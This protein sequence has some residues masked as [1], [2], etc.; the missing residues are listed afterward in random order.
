MNEK[1]GKFG[2]VL[3]GI[4]ILVSLLLIFGTGKK[5]ES[6]AAAPQGE[7]ER[8]E[9]EAYRTETEGRIR[10]L[11]SSMQG[12]ED[13]RVMVSFE[14][15]YVREYTAYGSSLP[16]VCLKPPA[17]CG[18]AVVCRGGNNAATQQKIADLLCALY[19]L[20]ITRVSV[21]G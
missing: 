9:L 10:S 5:A 14:S 19:H 21:S 13:V 18:I 7:A 15:G 6:S 20:D 8:A 16:L 1:P 17:V 3:I 11:L 4:G 2:V 12:V